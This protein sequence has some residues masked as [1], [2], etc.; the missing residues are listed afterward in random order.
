V[1][2]T[3]WF[4]YSASKSDYVLYCHNILFLLFIFSVVP[5]PLVFIEVLRWAGFDRYK[6]QPKVRLSL[7][8]MLNCYKDVMWMFFSVVGPL[9][10]ISYP[11]IQ[12]PNFT[13]ALILGNWATSFCFWGFG[14][15]VVGFQLESNGGFLSLTFSHFT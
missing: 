11:S 2:E 1:A 6:I 14:K 7:H 4:N 12:V 10:L 3:M 9:Q 15:L 13:S 5:L 8:D